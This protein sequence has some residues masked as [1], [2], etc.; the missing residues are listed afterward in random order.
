MNELIA[1]CGV[2]C[3]VCPDYTK[4]L[5]PSCRKTKWDD[6]PCMPV[7]C[8]KKKGITVCGECKNFPCGDMKEFY[9][10]SENHEKAYELMTKIKNSL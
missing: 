3:S 8:C 9:E 6:E 4:D 1:F 10:V 7:A 5:C 2:D